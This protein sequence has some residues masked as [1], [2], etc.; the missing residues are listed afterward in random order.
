MAAIDYYNTGD[1]N[2]LAANSSTCAAQTFTAS[3][4]YSITS[5]KLYM[6]R[7]A[8]N[9]PGTLT[10]GIRATASNKPT[11]SNLAV[12]TTDGNTLPNTGSTPE[13]REITFTSGYSLTSTGKY[14]IVLN[15]SNATNSVYWRIDVSSPSYAGGNSL[16]GSGESW[17]SA[18][19]WDC[20]FET[21]STP[22]T[23]T[24]T[25]AGTATF[26][27]TSTLTVAH[28]LTC[29]GNFALSSNLVLVSDWLLTC[30]GSLTISGTLN[31]SVLWGPRPFPN[32][33]PST[34]NPSKMWDEESRTWIAASNIAA[35]RYHR[36]LIVVGQ[37][38]VGQ[39]VIY[40][41]E[42]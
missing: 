22:I 25:C 19:T 21:Y 8:T 11:G 9:A 33:R 4:S 3:S 40:W 28:P 6:V 16:Y 23:H 37:D 2:Q 1:D 41:G 14:A 39:G 32:L 35:G 24:L 12:G 15:S 34:Y 18:T 13:W 17:T 27:G 5:V 7:S 30:I 20:L 38:A 26:S 36:T 42:A 31:L 10:V 29:V